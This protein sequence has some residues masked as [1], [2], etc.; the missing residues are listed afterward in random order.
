MSNLNYSKAFSMRRFLNWF[1]LGMAYA[2]LYMGRYSYIPAK[3]EFK[4]GLMDNAGLGFM[5]MV[6]AIV[7]GVSFLFNGPLTDKIGGRKAMIIS[8]AGSAVVNLAMGLLIY[9]NWT[10]HFVMKM[11]ILYGVNMYFQSFAAIAIVK[12]NSNWFHISERGVFGGIFGILISSGLFLAYTVSPFIMGLF[13]K[14]QPQFYFLIPS[15]LLVFM[16]FVTIM[17]IRDTPEE[18]GFPEFTTGTATQFDSDVKLSTMQIIKQVITHPIVISIAFIEL[19]T[20]VL[21]DGMFHWFGAFAKQADSPVRAWLGIG[22]FIAGASG[23]MVAGW[24][25][26]KLFNSRR[27][28]VAML[29]YGVIIVAL[30]VAA[31]VMKFAPTSVKPLIMFFVVVVVA[32][33]VIGTHG[34]LSG[35]ATADF[36]GKQA[37][38][39]ATGIIDGFVYLGVA[40]QGI[41]LGTLTSK[42]WEYWIP[43]LIP[44]AVMGFF[45][46]FRVRNVKP[47]MRAG[48]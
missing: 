27:P 2:T 28:P 44:F 46:S 4:G 10:E 1:P 35:A 39:T 13:F 34:V 14:G 25:S 45:L 17:L 37:T 18:C 23:S 15:F 47:A 16:M 6:G 40:I 11:A 21:R 22:L 26:D 12:V 43:F 24:I 48:H 8:T 30:V 20:G 29:L 38:A 19:C 7:Y 32:F 5:T 31:F 33:G 3:E 9:A 41:G 42:G 36:G